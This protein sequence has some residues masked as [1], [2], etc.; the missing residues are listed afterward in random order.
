MADRPEDEYAGA[1]RSA[2]GHVQADCWAQ[3]VSSD[4]RLVPP[5][6]RTVPHPFRAGEMMVVTPSRTLSASIVVDG[7]RIGMVE[8]AQDASGVLVVLGQL[9][10]VGIVATDIAERLDAEWIPGWAPDA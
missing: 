3:I 6:P 4:D 8:L 2:V 1:L 10:D 7:R 5:E 9:R